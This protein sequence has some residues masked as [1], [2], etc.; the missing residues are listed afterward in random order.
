MKLIKTI[1]E[2]I[3]HSCNIFLLMSYVIIYIHT[4][5]TTVPTIYHLKIIIVIIIISIRQSISRKKTFFTDVYPGQPPPPYDS[6]GETYH[7][8]T[9]DD[10]ADTSPMDVIAEP[11]NSYRYPKARRSRH[12]GMYLIYTL[13]LLE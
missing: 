10:E 12:L 1:E 8:L 6:Q 5:F 4:F 11:L 3:M 7:R 2:R 9:A 13:A